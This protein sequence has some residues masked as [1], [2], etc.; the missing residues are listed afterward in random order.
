M[1]TLV[2]LSTVVVKYG[3]GVNVV[4][5]IPSDTHKHTHTPVCAN[6]L[7]GPSFVFMIVFFI[8]ND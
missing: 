4:Y 6:C 3:D 8:Q 5:H 1:E 2:Q 7:V